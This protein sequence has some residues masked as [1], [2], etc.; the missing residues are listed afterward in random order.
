MKN[1]TKK[2]AIGAIVAGVAGYLTGILTAPKSGKETRKD[3][4]KSALKAKAE[5]E[6]TLKK[7]HSELDLL[8]NK[9]KQ[10]SQ[11]VSDDIKKQLDKTI[12]QAQIA[13]DKVRDVLSALHDGD[14][15]DRNLQTAIDEAKKAIGLLEVYVN[16]KTDA[17]KN[18]V[19]SNSSAKK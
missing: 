10:L 8:L 1:G 14:T 16:D 19:K 4:Q 11:T 17:V 15:D 13:K 12:A 5:A 3:I 18:A 2:I 6:K 9:A 7:I